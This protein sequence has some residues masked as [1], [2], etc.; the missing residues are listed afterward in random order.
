MT[1]MIVGVLPAFVVTGERVHAEPC[2]MFHVNL[3][4]DRMYIHCSIFSLDT[5]SSITIDY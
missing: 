1:S 4:E 3:H 5:N 2:G